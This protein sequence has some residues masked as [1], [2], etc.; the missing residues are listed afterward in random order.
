MQRVDS[1]LRWL[2]ALGLTLGPL[3]FAVLPSLFYTQVFESPEK[4]YQAFAEGSVNGYPGL[5]MQFG[6]SVFL[7]LAAL[8]IGGVTILRGRGRT[9]GIIGL[10]AGL[11]TSI[12]AFLVLGAEVALLAIVTSGSDTDSAV[13]LAVAALDVPGFFIPLMVA[14]IGLFLMLLLLGLALWRSGV[15]PLV[16]PLLFI[17][18]MLISFLPLP[19]SLA[20]IIPNLVLLVPCLG[21]SAQLVFGAPLEPEADPLDGEAAEAHDD[22]D[23]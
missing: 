3:G 19:T 22:I 21:I 18:P 9:L 6:G 11:A 15:V 2:G 17:A 5:A 13:A 1:I 8:G 16:G 20:S 10:I 14:L 12:S 7:L 4:Q 23:S